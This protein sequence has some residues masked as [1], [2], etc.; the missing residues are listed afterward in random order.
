MREATLDP[1]GIPAGESV[2]GGGIV[3][4]AVTAAT[5]ES[6][7]VPGGE[8]GDESAEGSAIEIARGN[9]HEIAL[10]LVVRRPLWPTRRGKPAVSSVRSESS[11]RGR[12]SG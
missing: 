3:V 4:I 7:V 6:E 9:P 1:E 10:V 12:S 2:R 11:Y 8:E 5:G